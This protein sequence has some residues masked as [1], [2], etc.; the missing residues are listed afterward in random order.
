MPALITAIEIINVTGG[1]LHMGDSAFT[2]PKL[3]MK[4]RGGSGV[5]NTGGVITSSSILSS[6]TEL[7]PDVVDQ[8]EVANL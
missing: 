5:F 4:T 3:T 2:T 1:V 7:N 6:T 8:P